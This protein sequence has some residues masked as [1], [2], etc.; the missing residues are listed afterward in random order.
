MQ[1]QAAF[2]DYPALS[3]LD[4]L[5]IMTEAMADDLEEINSTEPKPAAEWR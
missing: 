4:E 5:Q 1:P 3:S 2:P